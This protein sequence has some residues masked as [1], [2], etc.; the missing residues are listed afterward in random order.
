LLKR[1][2]PGA[3]HGPLTG[4]DLAGIGSIA[5][6]IEVGRT[7]LVGMRGREQGEREGK[8][9]ARAQE[10]SCPATHDCLEA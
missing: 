6:A 7:E 5:I 4:R 8:G 3:I 2:L 1:A 10:M 9:Q